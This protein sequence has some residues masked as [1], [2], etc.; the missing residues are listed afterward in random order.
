MQGYADLEHRQI[1]P[2][3][4]PLL[5]TVT[6][7][8]SQRTMDSPTLDSLAQEIASST[9]ILTAWL[10][11]DNQSE[12]SFLSS[13]PEKFPQSAAP[14]D[15]QQAREKLISATS[16]LHVLAQWPFTA[17]Q[18]FANT[19]AFDAQALRCIVSLNIA[20]HVPL[21]GSTSFAELAAQVEVDESRLRRVLRYAMTNYWFCEPE[22]GQV[23]HSAMSKLLRTS[24]A[25]RGQTS[26]QTRVGAAASQSWLES[27]RASREDRS[28]RTSPFNLSFETE[29]QS[30][31][32]ALSDPQRSVWFND[33]L[34]AYQE[35]GDLALAHTVAMFDW[36]SI[37]DCLLVDVGGNTG[38]TVSAIA[39]SAPGARFVVQDL[40]APIARGKDQ[41]HADLASR[42][43]FKE[44]DFFAPN[45]VSGP[46]IF[47]LR[48]VLHDWSDERATTILR[49][50]FA[51][52]GPE[53]KLLIVETIVRAPGTLPASAEK[54][55]RV[56]DLTMFTMM[57]S[58]ERTEEDWRALVGDAADGKAEIVDIVTPPGSALSM[59]VVVKRDVA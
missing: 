20:E 48:S 26:Y 9:K 27:L 29:M 44:H 34:K 15:V 51:A 28:H 5:N 33:M 39:A 6:R 17:A 7:E 56:L 43:E 38:T 46:S 49:H 24:D 35:S 14:R 32:W 52:M 8:Q 53:T 3:Y 41:L 1:L 21:Q 36:K 23:A 22:L 59:M 58:Q 16:Q 11:E 47:L 25:I 42:I 45:P 2:S 13:G 50:L 55:Q 37:D 57:N 31:S 54:R 12:P 30:M 18:S 19:R 40:P 4:V 10:K